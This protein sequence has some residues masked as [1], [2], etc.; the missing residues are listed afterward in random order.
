MKR[1]TLILA[2]GIML[3]LISCTSGG[4]GDQKAEESTAAFTPFKVFMV[5]HPVNEYNA[6]KAEYM[7][8]D[9]MREAFG[10]SRFV[11]GRGMDN[12]NMVLVIDKMTD[13]QKA[14]EFSTLPNLK[15]A[16]D[17]AGVSGTPTFAYVDVIRNDTTT[18][19]QKQRV[20]V[21]HRVKD[22]DAWLKVYDGEGKATR[23]EHGIVDRGMGRDIDD[24]NMVYLVFAITDVTKAKARMASEELKK[25]MT[26]AGVEGPPQ[27]F[28]YT[29][30]N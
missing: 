21:S 7:A 23:A 25:L 4:K 8:H 6:W 3:C 11:I 15:E 20:M 26:D 27:I 29:L 2:A 10:I 22:F 24:P 30:D 19:P 13:V 5:K 28:Y 1:I 18:I 14:K 17:K 16:M 9:S 12:P